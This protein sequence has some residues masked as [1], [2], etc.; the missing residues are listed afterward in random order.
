MTGYIFEHQ[1]QQFA[2]EG[3]AKVASVEAHNASL[4]T[5][6]M[7][8]VDALELVI[9]LAAQAVDD[10]EGETRTAQEEACDTVEALATALFGRDW[11]DYEGNPNTSNLR[12]PLDTARE[13]IERYMRDLEPPSRP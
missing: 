10:D 3:K 11:R 8:I 1:G 9:D 7:K 2:P 13:W 5:A 12:A 4:E 6:E